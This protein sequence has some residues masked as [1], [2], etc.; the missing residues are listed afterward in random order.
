MKELK[1]NIKRASF[2]SLLIIGIVITVIFSSTSNVPDII[3][4]GGQRGW[5]TIVIATEVTLGAGAS[6]LLNVFI[7]PHS[8]IGETAYTTNITE[9]ASY[10]HFD[11]TPTMNE[12]LE[13][14]VPYATTFDIVVKCQFNATHAYN[15]TGHT[16]MHS[17]VRANITCAD[18]GI[19]ALTA[20]TLANVT[21]TAGFIW[22]Q[23]YINNSN[24]GY[25]ITHG[26]SVNITE[27]VVQAFY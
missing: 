22:I 26:Q 9:A 17:W 18:L 8:D 15:S 5:N 16:W 25:T 24:A 6:G 7:A 27:L 14:N 10:A 23:F 12:S 13:G 11:G 1:N 4:S 19:G 3:S 20:M 2:I 21:A